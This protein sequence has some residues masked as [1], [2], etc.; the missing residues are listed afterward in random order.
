MAAFD[1]NDPQAGEQMRQMV[2]PQGVDQQLRQAISLCWSIM[3]PE[4]KT[5]EAI[6]AEIRRLVDRALKDL[7]EDAKA[8]GF[9]PPAA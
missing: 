3:P 5:V 1:E 7:R 2:G 9:E 8:F 6:E 4:R